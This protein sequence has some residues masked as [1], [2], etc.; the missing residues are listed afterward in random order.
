M[1][2]K[3]EESR[4][5]GERKRKKEKILF[6][7]KRREKFNKILLLFLALMNSAHLSID[8]HCSDG[9]EKNRFSSTAGAWVWCLRS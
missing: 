4:E 3:K 9:A 6:K 2:R 1:R 7:W 5:A 8:V